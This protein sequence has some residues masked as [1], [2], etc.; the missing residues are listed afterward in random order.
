MPAPVVVSRIQ[1]RR[2]T[3][4]QFNALYPAGYSGVG[5]FGVVSPLITT[6]VNSGSIV[7][8]VSITLN[9]VSS[10]PTLIPVGSQITVSG[11]TPTDWNSPPGETY[12]VTA[13]TATSVTYSTTVTDV[14]VSGPG[15]ISY[16][17]SLANYPNVLLPGELALCIDTR[18]IFLGNLNGEYLEI[19]QAS[20]SG[21]SI[22]PLTITLPPAATF[23]SI[24]SLTF[25]AVPFTTIWYDLVDGITIDW[26][27][28][29]TNFSRNGQLQITA[30]TGGGGTA[31][32]TDSS[33]EINNGSFYTGQLS[34]EALYTG[35][36]VEVLY[37]NTLTP[38]T[39]VTF[40]TSTIQWVTF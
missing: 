15:S 38:A 30:V 28:M 21:I 16:A 18:N 25:A 22:T 20:S 23:T 6:P 4:T 37:I 32:L 40:S 26:D 35:T 39:S 11:I 14:F 19:G 8:G 24:P 9:F 27:T 3:Q 36:N 7:P 31:T 29:G 33:T 5:G 12:T 13:S 34:F 10:L 2:G 1:N 17:F